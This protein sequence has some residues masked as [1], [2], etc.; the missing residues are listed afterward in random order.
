MTTKD[1]MGAL[2]YKGKDRICHPCESICSF[3][4]SAFLIIL[5]SLGCLVFTV[6][7]IGPLPVVILV[8]LFY[9]LGLVNSVRLLVK[10]AF[11]DPGIIPRVKNSAIDYEKKYKVR[12]RERDVATVQE[13]YDLNKF[14]LDIAYDDDQL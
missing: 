10:V 1:T 4:S 8:F 3:A 12:Y 13:F 9:T 5:P 6:M 11:T 7:E 2:T 14:K